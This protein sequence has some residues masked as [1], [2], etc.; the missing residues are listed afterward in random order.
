[1]AITSD[2]SV[3]PSEPEGGLD[4]EEAV[5]LLLRDLRASADGL[6]GV[7]AQRRLLQYGPNALNRR[8]GLRWPSELAAQLTHPLAL[9]LWA[10]A[11]LSFADGNGVIAI[12]VLLVIFLNAA[13]ALAQELQ[14][15]R[16]RGAVAVSAAEGDRPTRRPAMLAGVEP[17]ER[18]RPELEADVASDLIERVVAG[19]AASERLAHPHRAVDELGLRGEHRRPDPLAGQVAQRERGLKP[20]DAAAGDQDVEGL[21]VVGAH[22]DH[23]TRAWPLRQPP[24]A[25]P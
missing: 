4:P 11:A 20:R 9:L 5:G 8:R 18:V 13:F 25:E 21:S 7:E 3:L 2:S 6:T 17:L 1:V 23:A 10:A 22:G 12:A 24:G 16:R 15:E 14:A 19:T